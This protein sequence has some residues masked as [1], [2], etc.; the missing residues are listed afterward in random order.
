M[1]FKTEI[2]ARY[3]ETDQM[4]V[5][6]HVNY[7]SYF[8]LGRTAFFKEIGFSYGKCEKEGILFPVHNIEVTYKSPC[9]YEDIL[10]ITTELID[11]NEYS[12]T[13]KHKIIDSNNKLKAV[14]KSVLAHCEKETFKLKK[15]SLL[16]PEIHEK[17]NK[18]LRRD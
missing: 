2:S 4:G 12:T 1:I 17:Y 8:E 13:F 11:S 9:Y 16:C 15:L 3:S 6:Y 10:T 5:I 14:G 7:V 18:L